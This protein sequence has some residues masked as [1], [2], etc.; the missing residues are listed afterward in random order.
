[1]FRE[2]AG[3]QGPGEEAAGVVARFEID[4]G[5]SIESRFSELQEAFLYIVL[6]ADNS[7]SFEHMVLK[8]EP[9][10]PSAFTCAAFL[11]LTPR[12]FPPRERVS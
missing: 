2:F 4:E 9:T 6:F 10:Y 5:V 12:L 7:I 8:V 1:M 3:E 11:T